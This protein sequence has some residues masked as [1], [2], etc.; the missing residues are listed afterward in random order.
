MKKAVKKTNPRLNDLIAMLKE[1]SRT[2][3][4]QLWREIA[5]R[6]EAPKKNHAE[7]NVG[8]INRYANE[9]ESLLVPGK[10]LGS[11]ALTQ[12]VVV[13]AL[14]FS[15]SAESKITNARGKCISI[16]DLLRDNPSGSHVRI[17][18]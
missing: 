4:T 10:V 16:E 11:G 13:A 17:L 14:N 1:A 7:V 2:N 8:K 6:L 12:P 3:D 18:R 15:E 9:I 5:K